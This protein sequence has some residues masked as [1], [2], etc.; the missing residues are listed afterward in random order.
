MNEQNDG[1]WHRL[2]EAFE[3]VEFQKRINE[4]RYDIELQ[5]SKFIAW[6]LEKRLKA[7]QKIFRSP[8]SRIKS[9]ISFEE[10]AYRK[11]YINKWDISG[12]KQKI[13]DE[14]LMNLPDIIGFRITCY[15]MNDEEVIYESLNE[16][17]KLD[18][19]EN[20]IL[21]FSEGT[22]Q[23]NGKRI[24]KV[25][26][27]FKE[28]VRF[29]IQIKAATHNV[30]GEVEHR[31]IYKG[32]QYLI[33]HAERQTITE[34]IFNILKAADHQL[35]ALFKN[36]YTQ[37][38]LI[39]GLF[40]EQTRE[41]VKNVAKTDSLAGH[42]MSFFGIFFPESKRDIQKYV[43]AT[44]SGDT[45]QYSKRMLN[46]ERSD[47]IPREIVDTIK[48]TFL[49]YYLNVQY[50]IAQEL[51]AFKDYEEFL[52][53]MAKNV[54]KRITVDVDEDCITDDIF[55]ESE[56]D[57]QDYSELVINV[58]KDKMPDALRERK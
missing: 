17:Y 35:L 46:L 53:Y 55:A 9:R 19:L 36:N 7:N 6:L 10:K 32:S 52:L 18:K 14:I 31:T 16:Y 38:D 29:E 47:D 48:S 50:K 22:V 54:K 15:F 57:V 33:N 23:K 44:L 24:Y 30:W 28:T 56:V 34:E 13:Q 4:Y 27:K 43:A 12:S 11:D 51:Y 8:E 26:G 58:L 39:C 41:T 42:Y 2:F 45:T 25:S 37:E 3:D 21:D 20:I 1:R 40:A 5:L 49:E